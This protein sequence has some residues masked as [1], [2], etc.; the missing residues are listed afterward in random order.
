MVHLGSSETRRVVSPSLAI[1]ALVYQ[2]PYYAQTRDCIAATGLPV[3]W[4]DRKGVGNF[5]AAMNEAFARTTEDLIWFT[6][7]I[8]FEPETP[9]RLRER[10]L[11]N[12]LVIIQPAYLSD[13]QHLRPDGSGLVKR[14]PYLEWTAPLVRAEWFREIGGLDE[15][16]HYWMQDL[17]FSKEVRERGGAMGVDH[18]CV[19]NHV[20]HREDK[21]KH[22]VTKQRYSL[23]NRRV[24]IE[25]NLLARKFG[26]NWKDL[27]WWKGA[28]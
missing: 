10:L 24:P 7:D 18:G 23:R 12:E 19:I 27:L 1:V 4:A 2:E 17:I 16:F 14:V 8:V 22:P 13:H 11:E 25:R 5:S 21:V 15:D 20:Y 6:T 26:P 28:Y 3:Y 9:L